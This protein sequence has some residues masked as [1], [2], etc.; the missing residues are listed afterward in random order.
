MLDL[1]ERFRVGGRL[2]P[3]RW[4]IDFVK[5][6]RTDIIELELSFFEATVGMAFAAFRDARVDLAVIEVGMGGRLDSTNVLT[7][8]VS[9]VTSI[10][11]DH[12]TFLGPDRVS[13]AREKAGIFKP[14]VAA[15]VGEFDNEVRPVFEAIAA[16]LENC[17][18]L[19][20]VAHDEVHPTD[21]MGD[22]QINNVRTAVKA[23]RCARL[24]IHDHQIRRGLLRVASN[25]GIRG[26]WDVLE[27]NNPFI[28]ADS[29]HNA[30]GWV[31]VMKQWNRVRANKK[32]AMV[33]GVVND[34][35][36][37]EMIEHV[38]MDCVV[39]ACEPAIP[40]A[41][42]AEDWAQRLRSSGRQ[43]V[44]CVAVSEAIN[45][46][47]SHGFEAIYVGGSS[48]VVA[49]ALAAY[50]DGLVSKRRSASSD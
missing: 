3:E 11:L 12:M 38:P 5:A 16:Q 29:A 19:P 2:V 34:K 13:I 46:A 35:D 1:R 6:H 17:N 37:N 9:V 25:T 15:V 24:G 27:D 33:L 8:L 45:R 22:Y 4:V 28:V 50:R 10:G 40:R 30:H 31:P 20:V 7:P 23:A 39:F 43:V 44:Q 36:T 48:F 42:P 18:L 14:G 49:D 32:S 26:R 41:L 47:K 21:L